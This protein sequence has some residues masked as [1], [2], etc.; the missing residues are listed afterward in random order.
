MADYPNI[1]NDQVILSMDFL[2]S[3]MAQ[4]Y[5]QMTMPG[6]IGLKFQP[7]TLFMGQAAYIDIFMFHITSTNNN[8]SVWREV[9][10]SI[11]KQKGE[12]TPYNFIGV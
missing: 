12:F 2:S 7:V 5:S 3:L 1:L 6:F 8:L 4:T 11:I 9:R 10:V